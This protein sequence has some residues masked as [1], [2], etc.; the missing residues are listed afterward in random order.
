MKRIKGDEEYKKS[1]GDSPLKSMF[2]TEELIDV[3]YVP[4]V[5]KDGL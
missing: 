2:M 5:N 4:L 3:R 1:N